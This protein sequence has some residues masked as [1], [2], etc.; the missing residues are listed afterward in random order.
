MK[1]Q[2]Q[3]ATKDSPERPVEQNVDKIREIIF[4]VQMRDY[5]QRF[6]EL[7]SHIR[8]THD[9]LSERL[10]QK[11]DGLENFI[12]QQFDDMTTRIEKERASRQAQN[13][14]D[15]KYF[16]ET[17][18]AIEGRFAD[19]DQQLTTESSALRSSVEEQRAELVDLVKGTHEQLAKLIEGSS[20]ELTN[21]K[22]A[23]RELAE[24][25]AEVAKRL[26]AD[27]DAD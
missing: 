17:E 23:R 8:Q 5:E 21:K 1:K 2:Q 24:L 4:G 12:R 16:R 3:L 11:I 10:L 13:D 14:D 26:D 20:K 9:D 7:E 18:S 6:E 22:V 25:L 27:S 15:Q 19:F